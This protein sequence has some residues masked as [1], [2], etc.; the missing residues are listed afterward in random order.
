MEIKN[1]ETLHEDHLG[2]MEDITAWRNELAYYSRVV[3]KLVE[4]IKLGPD[5]A[6]MEEFQSRFDNMQDQFKDMAKKITAHDKAIAHENAAERMEEH[7]KMGDE[8][9]AFKGK[10]NDLKEEFFKFEEKFIYE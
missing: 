10:F 2:W 4:G 7:Q 3:I 8:V 5:T 6:K 9:K 1:I